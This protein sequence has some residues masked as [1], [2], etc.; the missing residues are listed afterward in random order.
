MAKASITIDELDKLVRGLEDGITDLRDAKSSLTGWISTYE[1]D[2]DLGNGLQA[3]ADWAELEL[4]GVRRRLALAEAIEGSNPEWPVGVAEIDESAISDVPPAEAEGNGAEAANALV[5]S[6][7]EGDPELAAEVEANMHDPYFAAGFADA[8]SPEEI[9]AALDLIDRVAA[10]NGESE[11]E[12]FVTLRG[13]LIVGTGTTLSTATRNTGELALPDGY[14]QQWLDAITEP[15]AMEEG[16][17]APPNQAQYLALLLEQGEYST[18]FLDHVG[19]GI[20]EYEQSAGGSAVW[21]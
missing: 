7:G 8:A 15:T 6:N 2:H 17:A 12:R 16:G 4:P 18:P 14:A 3:A 20:Y 11:S 5:T 21:G 9:T 10:G 19:D 1:I 13:Q